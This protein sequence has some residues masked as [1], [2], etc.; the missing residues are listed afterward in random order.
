MVMVRK[1]TQGVRDWCVQRITAILIGA[2]TI[3][4]LVM[5]GL[6]QPLDFEQWSGMFHQLWMKLF[7]LI[8]LVSILWHAWIGLWTVFTDYVKNTTVRLL[9]QTLVCVL[10]VVYLSWGIFILWT[11]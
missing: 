6:H 5:I 11:C 10:F 9:L 8:V 3:F 1:N 7:T 2:Y 4:L